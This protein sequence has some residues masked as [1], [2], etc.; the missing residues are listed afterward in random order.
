LAIRATH[1]IRPAQL[2]DRFKAF[3]V[4]NQMLDV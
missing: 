1:S 3:G 2:A 4:V